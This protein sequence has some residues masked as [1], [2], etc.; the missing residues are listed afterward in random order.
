MR[1]FLSKIFLI[2]KNIPKKDII[3]VEKGR[4]DGH[5]WSEKLLKKERI[6]YKNFPN[7]LTL[8]FC[9]SPSYY[10]IFI[11]LYSRIN[12]H[13]NLS[14]KMYNLNI[15]MSKIKNKNSKNQK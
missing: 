9:L 7:F 4:V 13:S 14:V 8:K 10:I 11:I 15:I 3:K 6:L 5:Q 12:L 1:D 2:V